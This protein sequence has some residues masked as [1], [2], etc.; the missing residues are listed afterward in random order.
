M[1][2]PMSPFAA[3]GPSGTIVEGVR[4]GALVQT[5]PWRAAGW[6]A[7]ETSGD[8][9]SSRSSANLGI[10]SYASCTTQAF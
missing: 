1:P 7:E 3:I 6:T 10:A 5:P 4:S 9:S 2:T 8:S